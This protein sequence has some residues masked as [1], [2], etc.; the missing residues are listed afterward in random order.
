ML[1]VAF[2]Q[3][4]KTALW[5]GGATSSPSQIPV[6][7]STPPLTLAWAK[8]YQLYPVSEYRL[9]ARVL[10]RERYW[11]DPMARLM[12]VD[13]A[14]AWGLSA[15]AETAQRLHI[16]QADRWYLISTNDD[17]R[18]R[19]DE[20]ANVHLIGRTPSLRRAIL[21]LDPGDRVRFYGQLVDIRDSSGG[22]W[23]T[24]RTRDDQGAGA[25]ET[26]L[27]DSLSLLP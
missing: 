17:T 21:R 20:S 25:C 19:L 8:E 10:R 14:L 18:L 2:T 6:A 27:V 26:L 1:G 15:D 12:P 9:D 11:F 16:H 4:Q 7:D 3:S 24:S 5:R 23:R 13:L 22:W